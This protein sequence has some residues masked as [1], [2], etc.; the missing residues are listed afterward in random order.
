MLSTSSGTK[1]GL[2]FGKF[3]LLQ[4]AFRKVKTK[5]LFYLPLKHLVLMVELY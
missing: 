4:L 3:S 5:G 1:E 2:V